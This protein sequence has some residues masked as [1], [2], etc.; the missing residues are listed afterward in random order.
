MSKHIGII[1]AGPGG[2]TAGMILANRG[3]KVTILERETKVGGRNSC[4]ELGPYKF[5]LGPTFLMMRYIL[6]EVFEAAGAKSEELLDFVK[7]DPM[8]R[9]Q[10]HDRV[11]Q[12]SPD[13]SKVKEEIDKVFPG[14]SDSFDNYMNSERERFER[15]VPCLQMPYDKISQL[16]HINTLK[17]LKYALSKRSVFQV[18][19]DY[20]GDEKLALAFSFQSKYLGMSPWECPGFF[21]ML[22]FVEYEYG[23]EHTIG[24]LSEI[25]N[26]MAKVVWQNG[27]TI[28]LNHEVESLILDK[29]TAK[30]VKLTNGESMMFDEVIINSDFAYSMSNLVD[31]SK[32]KKYNEKGLDKKRFSC[33]TFMLYIGLDKLYEELPH[34]SIIFAESY[35]ENVKDIFDNKCLSE[36]FSF[37]IR[38]ASLNDSTL[39]PEGHSAIY[40]LV[41]APNQ[42]SGID[43]EKEEKSFKDKVLNTIM[44]KL[45]V[46]DFTDHIVEMETITPKK[47][48]ERYNVYR[49]ATFNLAH[50]TTQMLYFRPHNKF[51]EFENC[52]LVGGGTHPGSGLPTIYES[53]RITADLITK[54]YG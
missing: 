37:Y 34:H 43:W 21:A 3:F 54:K 48:E 12:T 42:R 46:P 41:P 47:W 27:G 44:E 33:S 53:G 23:V 25:S 26:A 29:K 50:N 13:H 31:Q 9:L 51:E 28:K 6:D 30:G 45:N 1:G 4:L 39:A 7:L 49:G 32:L 22:G 5:D 24:G 35:K 40:V 17:V 15:M 52:Y 8:Y 36:E 18:L 38:N 14:H 2:L 20:F 19:Y 16:F 10:F 11:L